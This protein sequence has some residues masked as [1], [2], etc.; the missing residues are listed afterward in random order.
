ML[1]WGLGTNKL[2]NEIHSSLV[3]DQTKAELWDLQQN[4]ESYRRTLGLTAKLWDEQ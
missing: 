2:P 3:Q 1:K 4:S